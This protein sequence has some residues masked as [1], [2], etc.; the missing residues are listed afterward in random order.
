MDEQI[1]VLGIC[2]GNGVCLYPFHISKKYKV[3]GNIE[4]RQ[5]FYTKHQQQ[6]RSNFDH[7]P[8]S[9]EATINHID[10]DIIV[11]H[12]DCGD[13]S[14]L[15]LSRAKKSGN[16]LNNRS[17][18]T[19]FESIRTYN[20][21]IWL[22]ENLPNFLKTYTKD[23]LCGMF[24]EYHL[25]FIE[26]PV[27]MFGN[28]QI[29]R[30]RLVILG[31]S[32]KM[33]YKRGKLEYLFEPFQVSKPKR[34]IKYELGERELVELGHVREPLSMHCNMYHPESNRRSLSYQECQKLWANMHPTQK[35]WPVGG[36]M[37][38]QPG[39]TRNDP[40]DWPLT[41]RKQNRQFGSKGLVLSPREMA[42]IQGVPHSYKLVIDLDERVYWINKARVSVTKTMPYQIPLW[43][44]RIISN[45]ETGLIEKIKMARRASRTQ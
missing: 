39:V 11:G 33:G 28:P 15:R 21:S 35:R 5:V 20:P 23:I 30:K 34:A 41:V 40:N 25:I 44:K 26:G 13:S 31:I 42:N 37:K 32:K 12:P 7:I 6:W 14:V 19:F 8:M 3:L 45:K 38:N 29:S 18:Q 43:L 10:V 36:K 2:A 1:N 9:K 16:V 4:P 27:S 24:P 22:L 17:I